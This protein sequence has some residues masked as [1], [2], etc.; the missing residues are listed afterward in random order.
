ML[1]HVLSLLFVALLTTPAAAQNPNVIV[2]QGDNGPGKGKHIV[3]L[4]GDHEYRSE[5][6]NAGRR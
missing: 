5:I 6:R 3:F 4:A 1:K 2:Y